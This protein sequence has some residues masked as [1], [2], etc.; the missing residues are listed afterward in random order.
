MRRLVVLAAVLALALS[1]SVPA[2]AAE[3]F[4][5]QFWDFSLYADFVNPDGSATFLLEGRLPP[6]RYDISL[7]AG[8]G[9]WYV[10][11]YDVVL[12]PGSFLEFAGLV[13]EREMQVTVA[14]IIDAYCR[15]T[16]FVGDVYGVECSLF[17]MYDIDKAAFLRGPSNSVLRFVPVSSPLDSALSAFSGLSAVLGVVLHVILGNWFTSL[18][19]CFSLIGLGVVAFRK[20]RRSR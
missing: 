4:D 5:F 20:L 18:F 6:G 11:A 19:L 17:S 3:S 14:G 12:V 15:T 7:L 1:L 10:G 2:F 16:L 8:G 13:C 9:E